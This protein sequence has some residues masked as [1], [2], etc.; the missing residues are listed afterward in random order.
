MVDQV[1]VTAILIIASVIAVVAF[2][3]AVIP[4]V[5]DLSNSFNSFANN[6]GDQYQTAIAVVF[7]YPQGNNVTIWMKNVGSTDIPF[8]KVNCSD[9]FVY[10][11]SNSWHPVFESNLTPSWNY[12][13]V[14]GNGGDMWVPKETIQVSIHLDSLSSNT[15]YQVKCS[16]YNGVS[17]LDV[18][19]T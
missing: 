16:L 3:D 1:V 15:T 11:S 18:F 10:S 2:V 6:I 9:F 8:S 7:V 14:N 12:V 19:S 17:S 5:Y 13:L 4:S